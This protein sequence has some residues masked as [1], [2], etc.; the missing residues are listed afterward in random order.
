MKKGKWGICDLKW[1]VRTLKTNK[2]TCFAQLSK[3]DYPD[4][5]DARGEEG[6]KEY[7]AEP[8]EPKDGKSKRKRHNKWKFWFWFEMEP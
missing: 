5:N 8:I 3:I 1:F 6:C 2:I 7:K 4:C